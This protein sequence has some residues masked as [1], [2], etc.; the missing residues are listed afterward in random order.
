MRL[1]D[2]QAAFYAH[3]AGKTAAGGELGRRCFVGTDRLPVE[4][5]I[6]IYADMYIWRQVEALR[7]DFPNLAKLLGDGDFYDLC[8]A[9]VGEQPSEHPSLAELGRG[10]A[11]FLAARRRSAPRPDLPDLA[12]LEWARARVFIETDV[13]PVT[14]KVLH[15]ALSS[16][17]RFA[18]LRLTFVPAFRVLEFPHDVAPLWQALGKGDPPP[19]L[20]ARE[21][22]LVVWRKGFEVFHVAIDA[23]EAEAIATAMAGASLGEVCNAFASKADPTRAAFE[24]IASWFTEGWVAAVT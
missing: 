12:A 17:D 9:Y 3:L 1:A 15:I 18:D 10:L 2:I 8:A 21:T 13:Q 16:P 19:R 22:N 24:S 23:T 14:E 4:A 11:S 5:R 7:E 6:Q 20:D